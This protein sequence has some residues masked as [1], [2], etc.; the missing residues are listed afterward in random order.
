MALPKYRG[1]KL[2]PG[3]FSD[4]T[5]ECELFVEARSPNNG[6]PGTV[7]WDVGSTYNIGDAVVYEGLSYNSLVGS[8]LGNQP[9]TSPSEWKP[10]D[11]K[12]GDIFIQVPS[13]GFPAGGGDVDIFLKVD[14]VWRALAETSPP[15]VALVDG[16][17]SEAT[18]VELPAGIF[19]FAEISYTVK[20]GSGHSRKRKGVFTILNDG[21]TVEYSHEFDEIGAD[22]NVPFS[23][24]IAGGLIRLRYTSVLEGSAIE[25]KYSVKGWA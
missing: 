9:D 23:V 22:V 13:A 16:Q 25:L 20:R 19:P 21:S 6:T 8:N 10:V 18:A 4:L 11:G 3:S 5:G 12:D 1:I 14:T 7:E 17:L 24:D 15:T 2:G